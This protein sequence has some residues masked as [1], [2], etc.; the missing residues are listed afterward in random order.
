MHSY[1]HLYV[2][3]HTCPHIRAHTCT[4]THICMCTHTHART[5]MH[6]H[7]LNA[8]TC[9]HT[10]ICIYTHTHKHMRAHTHTPM[11]ALTSSSP[12][13]ALLCAHG[14]FWTLQTQQFPMWLLPGLALYVTVHQDPS[15]WTLLVSEHIS[16]LQRGL[17]Y[18]RENLIFVPNSHWRKLIRWLL[19]MHALVPGHNHC[20][21]S[22]HCFLYLMKK[23]PSSWL[24][25]VEQLRVGHLLW[26]SEY[27]CTILLR[28]HMKSTCVHAS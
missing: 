22:V 13:N 27:L 6:T 4:H 28:V 12:L 2:Y 7:A 23:Q 9:T 15:P 17:R 18:H 20:I 1:T 8:H 5:Y 19:E 26:V 10:H 24:N 11:H 16:T 14:F 25:V 3:T 21:P